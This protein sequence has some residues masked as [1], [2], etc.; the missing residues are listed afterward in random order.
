MNGGDIYR[1][2]KSMG[3]STLALAQRYTHL[4]PKYLRDGV[5]YIGAPP[6]SCGDSVATSGGVRS[7]EAGRK[8][9]TRGSRISSTV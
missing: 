3:H 1:F 9:P 8:P 2:Q 6:A 5:Q 4:S 7:H